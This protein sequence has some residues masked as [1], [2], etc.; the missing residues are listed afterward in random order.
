MKQGVS[1][2]RTLVPRSKQNED[3][4]VEMRG[5]FRYKESKVLFLVPDQKSLPGGFPEN[6][7][8]QSRRREEPTGHRLCLRS[9]LATGFAFNVPGSLEVSYASAWASV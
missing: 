9:P 1:E 4:H 6:R 8:G 2:Q 7:G 3:S 5:L